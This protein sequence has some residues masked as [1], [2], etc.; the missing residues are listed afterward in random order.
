MKSVILL[1][2]NENTK[3]VEEE[4][5]ARFV[6]NILGILNLPVG[7][8][9]NEDL[10]MSV[11]N[12]IKYINF[13]SMY[14]IDIVDSIDGELEIY[15]EDKKIA[16]WEKPTYVLKKDPSQVNPRRKL[17]LEM[18]LNYWSVFDENEKNIST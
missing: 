17:F 9:W 8:L 15:C 7:D 4:E 13:L 14:S 2:Y 5:K 3:Q 16:Q 6:Q 12:R 11:E 1:N 10:T 18:H